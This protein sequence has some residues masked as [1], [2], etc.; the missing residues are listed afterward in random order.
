MANEDQMHI[1]DSIAKPAARSSSEI[2][3]N[4]PSSQCGELLPQDCTLNL[5]YSPVRVLYTSS[6]TQIKKHEDVSELINGDQLREL[7][8]HE[9]K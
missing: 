5:N 8:P 3:A 9:C 1:T 6:Q 4:V 7:S 2:F